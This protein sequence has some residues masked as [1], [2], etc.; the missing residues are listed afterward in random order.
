MVIWKAMRC[1]LNLIPESGKE[2]NV[3]NRFYGNGNRTSPHIK[4]IS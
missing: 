4:N 3:W 2:L 1:I